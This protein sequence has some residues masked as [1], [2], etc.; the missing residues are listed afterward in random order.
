MYREE[1]FVQEVKLPKP[2]PKRR[3]AT[4]GKNEDESST[5]QLENKN[6]VHLIM[7]YSQTK[8]WQ[9]AQDFQSDSDDEMC[10]VRDDCEETNNIVFGA[11]SNLFVKSP[12]KPHDEADQLVTAA[13]NLQSKNLAQKGQTAKSRNKKFPLLLGAAT[14][15]KNTASLGKTINS[16]QI[17]RVSRTKESMHRMLSLYTQDSAAFQD[18]TCAADSSDGDQS[19]QQQYTTNKST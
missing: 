5:L 10:Q 3:T 19:Q 6:D 18:E 15:G 13:M 12:R 7:Q 17:G 16:S 8:S 9:K 2:K 1:S 14:T 11:T 4:E